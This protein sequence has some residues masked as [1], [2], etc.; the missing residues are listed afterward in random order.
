M[1]SRC[2]HSTRWPACSTPGHWPTCGGKSP[3]ARN[4]DWWPTRGSTRTHSAVDPTRRARVFARRHA[5][6][7][8]LFAHA[9]SHGALRERTSRRV[10]LLVGWH[11]PSAQFSARV[12]VELAI[13][14]GKVD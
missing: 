9:R 2:W 4:R 12:D 10:A 8:V 3:T 5:A 11:D 14:A 1:S 7:F 6:I 13:D